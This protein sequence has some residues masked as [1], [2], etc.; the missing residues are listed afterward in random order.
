MLKEHCYTKESA[1]GRCKKLAVPLGKSVLG[2][3]FQACN[4]S[5][6]AS[7]SNSN[8]ENSSDW[9]TSNSKIESDNEMPEGTTETTVLEE[10]TLLVSQKMLAQEK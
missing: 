9:S 8:K 10:N 5:E 6:N 3:H 7:C 4:D 2:S 1:T